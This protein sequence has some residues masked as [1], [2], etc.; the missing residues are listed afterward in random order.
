M[1][2]ELITLG[3]YL[4][5][6]QGTLDTST[7]GGYKEELCVVGEPQSLLHFSSYRF[8]QEI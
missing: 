5:A 4:Y 6:Q 7:G 8:L 1:F 2:I 3:L